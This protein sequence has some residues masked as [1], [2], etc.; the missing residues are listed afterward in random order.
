M[1]LQGCLASRKDCSGEGQP[2]A[3]TEIMNICKSA[4]QAAPSKSLFIV[5]PDG[6][7][8]TGGVYLYN[9]KE[10]TLITDKEKTRY[11]MELYPELNW[12]E[13]IELKELIRMGLIWQYLSLKVESIG[14][15]VSQRAKVPKKIKQIVRGSVYQ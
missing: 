12:N 7:D 8:Y 11:T 13:S 2:L 10:F 9:N 3:M 14:L 5:L 4:H 1:S 15:G 6:K